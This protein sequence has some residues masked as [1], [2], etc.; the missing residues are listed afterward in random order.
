MAST[1]PSNAGGAEADMAM[2]RLVTG[3][4]FMT[5]AGLLFANGDLVGK[6]SAAEEEDGVKSYSIRLGGRWVQYQTLSP[7]AEMLGIVADMGRIFRDHDIND[8]DLLQGIGGGVLAAI[9]NNI[10]NK[11][12]LQGIGDFWGHDRPVVHRWRHRPG[13]ARLEGSVERRLDRPRSRP[14]S[15]TSPRPKTR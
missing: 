3:I 9:V 10:V 12:A 4:G 7:V 6:R 13:R 11:A 14:S 1:S 15:A 8:D 5:T 2:A